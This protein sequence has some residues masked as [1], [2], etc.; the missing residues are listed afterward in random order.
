[1]VK[2]YTGEKV[3]C[4]ACDEAIEEGEEFLQVIVN[5]VRMEYDPDYDLKPDGTPSIATAGWR[6]NYLGNLSEE[7]D[8]RPVELHG[9]CLPPGTEYYDFANWLDEQLAGRQLAV[10]VEVPQ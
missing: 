9:R 1:M 4:P 3:L 7:G 5:R 10:R 2:A 8:E 6:S